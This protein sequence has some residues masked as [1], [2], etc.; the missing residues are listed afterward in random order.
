MSRMLFAAA[1]LDA[2][3]LEPLFRHKI[4]SMLQKK[5]L[6]GERVIELISN[7]RH[8]GFN[9]Y[10]SVRIYPGDTQSMKNISRYI[11]K[12]SFSQERMNYM[13]NEYK[14]KYWSRTGND[15]KEFQSLD[16]IASLCSHIHNQNEQTVRYNGYIVTCAGEEQGSG[17]SDY[18][19]E[20]EE[21]N[22]SCSKKNC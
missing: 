13:V 18:V 10:S 19:I 8:S 4:L 5:G 2:T 21:Y 3:S 15:T 6:I 20:D 9:V 7:W 17:Q 1:N 22:K 12:A 14:A 16:F 11:I